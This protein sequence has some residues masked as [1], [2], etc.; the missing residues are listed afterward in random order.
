MGLAFYRKVMPISY[1]FAQSLANTIYAS[2]TSAAAYVQGG[3]VGYVRD[4]ASAGVYSGGTVYVTSGT[5][6]A[7]SGGLAVLG[8][9]ITKGT[10][11]AGGTARIE[12]TF[13]PIETVGIDWIVT[14]LSRPAFPVT[15]TA[16]PGAAVQAASSSVFPTAVR[17][18]NPNLNQWESVYGARARL[19]SDPV[20]RRALSGPRATPGPQCRYPEVMCQGLTG[21]SRCVDIN[22]DIASAL[23]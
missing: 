21:G 17:A 18:Y 22:K 4:G 14:D 6:F 16:Y 1:A 13:S 11:A 10:A 9:G 12:S 5:F 15:F 23:G 3:N 2:G 19:P 8:P 20:R 7:Q